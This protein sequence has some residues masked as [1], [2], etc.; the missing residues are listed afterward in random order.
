MAS[1]TRSNKTSKRYTGTLTVDP[2]LMGKLIGAGGCN[3]RRITSQVRAGCYIRGKGDKFEIS[4]WT[5]LAV[6]KAAQMIKMDLAALKDPNKRPSKPFAIF[7]IDPHIVPHIVGRGGDGL[8]AIMTK[9]GDGCYI[10]HRDGAFHISANSKSQLAFAKRLILQHKNDFIQWNQQK[11][12]DEHDERVSITSGK[13]DALAL[14]SDDEDEHYDNDWLAQ[15]LPD[16]QEL[17][18]HFFDYNG[19]GSIRH[20]KTTH[21]IAKQVAK[22]ANVHISQVDTRLIEQ[23]RDGHSTKVAPVQHFPQ[24]Q[25]A[26]PQLPGTQDEGNVKLEITGKAWKPNL[27]PKDAPVRD[28]FQVQQARKLRRKKD[29]EDQYTKYTNLYKSTFAKAQ[30]ASGDQHKILSD[31]AQNYKLEAQRIHKILNPS[32]AD[33]ADEDSDDDLD[34]DSYYNQPLDLGNL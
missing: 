31:K 30:L 26:F 21:H 16:P 1:F 22:A 2:S 6:K 13:Y 23:A 17:K 7:K 4:A 15:D 28:S 20:K 25:S 11:Q 19:N 8:R 9:V 12:P 14:S 27:A 10:V 29:M 5:Q 32:W 3:I 33:M 18:Q 24:E 34:N